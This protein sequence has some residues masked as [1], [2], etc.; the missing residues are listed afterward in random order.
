M[1]PFLRIIPSWNCTIRVAKTKVLISFAVTAKISF[2]VTAKLISP[3]DQLRSYCDADFACAD[4]WFSH[5]A[6]HMSLCSKNIALGPLSS[7]CEKGKNIYQGSPTSR[8][9]FIEVNLEPV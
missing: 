2:A 7:C 5:A 9:L 1:S 6:A 3:A 4:F 8:L